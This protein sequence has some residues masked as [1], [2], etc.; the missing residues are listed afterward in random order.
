MTLPISIA[1]DERSY[2]ALKRIK[3]FSRSPMGQVPLCSLTQLAMESDLTRSLG[4]RDMIEQFANR[5]ARKDL[6]M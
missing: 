3:S 4:F 1:V 5:S 6:M 2:S